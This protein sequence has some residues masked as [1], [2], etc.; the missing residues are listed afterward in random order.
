MGIKLAPNYA[1]L[2]MSDFETK[3]VTGDIFLIWEHSLEE[4]NSLIDLL[5]SVHPTIKFTK[6]ISDTS[7]TYL[8]LDIYKKDIIH[9][10][11]LQTDFLIYMA[12]PIIY[13]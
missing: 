12:N 7:I 5:N 11:S 2:F 8:D 1:N 3:H 13:L 10:R 6:S 9:T 4:L